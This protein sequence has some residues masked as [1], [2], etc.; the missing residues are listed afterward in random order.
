MIGNVRNVNYKKLVKKIYPKSLD[1]A[2]KLK[3]TF[4]IESLVHTLDK[5][6]EEYTHIDLI[7]EEDNYGEFA[8]YSLLPFKFVEESDEE[9]EIRITALEEQQIKKEKELAANA[10]YVKA[11]NKQKDLELLQKLALEN[12]FYLKKYK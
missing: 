2:G 3:E 9:Y 7:E 12:G 8:N 1:Q 10:E 4:S 6:K 11:F 5:F